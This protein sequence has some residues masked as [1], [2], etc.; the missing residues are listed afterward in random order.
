VA[1]K[2]LS[3]VD[4]LGTALVK[5]LETSDETSKA[6]VKSNIA[7]EVTVARANNIVYPRQQVGNE[8]ES[9]NWVYETGSTIFLP[10]SSLGT[11]G[12]SVLKF[13]INTHCIIV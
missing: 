9:E 6:I 2:I 3:A 13:S 12:W 11:Q 10:A 8:S 1:E 7:I 4:K 5:Q